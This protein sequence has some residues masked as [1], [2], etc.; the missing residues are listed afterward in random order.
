MNS[1]LLLPCTAAL[2][3]LA[4]T[5]CGKLMRARMNTMRNQCIDNLRQIEGAVEQAKMEREAPTA[6]NIFGP[7]KYIKEAPVCPASKAPYSL[8]GAEE[9]DWRPVCPNPTIHGEAF[10]HALP[11]DYY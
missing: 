1:R 6:A 3:L 5:G 7:D 2:A 10:E 8:K 4:L 11:S 9:S